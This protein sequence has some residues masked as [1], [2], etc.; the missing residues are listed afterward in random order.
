MPLLENVIV[1]RDQDDLKKFGESGT[2]FIGMHIV[3]EGEEAK[4]TNAVLMDVT[5]P[6]VVLVVGKRGTGKCVE[7]NTPIVLEDGSIIPIKDL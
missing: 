5:K 6:H 1:G 3:G 4:L 7:E 2:A